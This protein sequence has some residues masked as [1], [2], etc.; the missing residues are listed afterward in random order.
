MRSEAHHTTTDDINNYFFSKFEPI[1]WQPLECCW[2]SLQP[3]SQCATV[4]CS[5][6]V[7]KCMR[8]ASSIHTWAYQ[9]QHHYTHLHG[10][11]HKF[12]STYTHTRS[13]VRACLYWNK[14]SYYLEAI[15]QYHIKRNI[16][17]FR[18]FFRVFFLLY[19]SLSPWLLQRISLFQFLAKPPPP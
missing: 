3:I 1:H 10:L 8:I 15:K 16:R 2:E 17:I 7:G 5:G 13:C 19:L 11:I 12:T 6:M 14:W 9:H 4:V 18:L